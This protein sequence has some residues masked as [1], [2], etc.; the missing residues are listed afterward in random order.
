MKKWLMGFVG[1]L[2]LTAGFAQAQDF[3]EGVHYEVIADEATSTPEIAEFFSFYCVHCYRFEPIAK[4]LEATYPEAFEKSHVSFI[5][6]TG[7]VG[8]TMTQA[9]VVAQ[10]L[11]KEDEL[12]AA[13]FD[14]NFN[15]NSMLTS[16][17]DIR[18]V[19][20]VNG[21]SG[22]EFDKAMA[23]FSVRAA[24]ANMDRRATE[25]GVNATPTFIVN[26]KYKMLPQGFR[27]SNN[28]AEDFSDLAG[29]LLEK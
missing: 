17:Q 26:G 1:A 18:N 7:D 21:V 3:E 10:K 19:F 15:K 9:F 27:D 16:K 8:E 11:D 6:P 22:E 23:S 14:Y 5:S 28:F 20:I 2:M 13:I 25:L 29:Y 4:E 12:T 24:A